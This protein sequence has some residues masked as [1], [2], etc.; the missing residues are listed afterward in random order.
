MVRLAVLGAGRIGKIHGRN[1]A[2]HP[3]ARLISV[4]DPHQPSAEA[5]AAETGARVSTIDEAIAA[6][7]VDAVLICTPTT[8]HADLIERAVQAGKAVFCEKP[9]DLS[10]DRIRRCLTEVGKAG[11]PL[12]IGFNR[13]FDPN[14]ATL[15]QRIVDG[16]IGEVE[17]VT[18]ISRDPAPPPVSYIE[19]SGGLFRDMMIHD[20]DLARFLLAEEPV[21]VHA[22]ASAL[23]DP[24]IGKAGDVDTAAVLLKTASGKIAQ[25]SNSRRATYGYDQ[26]IEVHGSKGLIRAHNVPKTTVEVATGAGFL[27][28]PVQDF[29]LERYAEAYRLEMAAFLDAIL[30]GKSPNPSGE[31]GL[32][33]Q[34]LADAATQSAQTGNAIKL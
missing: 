13:R 33:A 27:A 1:A 22:V 5:L 10:S 29:F 6:S 17:L 23:V 28:D 31:D 15:K 21:E 2:L 32:K 19:S 3:Q 34:V 11:K 8:T 24:A 12:M 25:I 4:S 9:V 16:S 30:A 20:L 18:I 7:D 14:F 26:R